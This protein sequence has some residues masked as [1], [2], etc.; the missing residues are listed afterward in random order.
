MSMK[1]PCWW[2]LV[3]CAFISPKGVVF[4]YFYFKS[5]NTHGACPFEFT[6]ASTP[7]GLLFCCLPHKVICFPPEH[8]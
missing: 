6:T 3:K 7:E 1:S 5:M 2:P 8:I 4:G